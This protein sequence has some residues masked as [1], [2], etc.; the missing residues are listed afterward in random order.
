MGYLCTRFRP[1]LV[2]PLEGEEVFFKR[3][4]KLRSLVGEIY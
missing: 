3:F 4:W 1:T 2:L